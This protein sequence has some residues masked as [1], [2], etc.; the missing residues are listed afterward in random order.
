MTASNQPTTRRRLLNIAAAGSLALCEAMVAASFQGIG[1]LP[2]G[3]FFSIATGVSSNGQ[4]VVGYSSSALSGTGYEAFRWAATNGMTALGDLPGGSFSSFANAVSEDGLVIVGNSS[5][6]NNNEAFRWT[7]ATGMI[8][9]GDLPGGSVF[10]FA[11]AVSADG[12]VVIGVSSS[13]LSGTVRGEAFRW[14][15]TNGMFGLGDLPGGNFDSDS[16]G[17]SA[18][19]SVIVGYSSSSNGTEAF[20]WTSASGMAPLGDLA[21]GAFNSIAYGV[22][23]DGS[24][25]VGYGYTATTSHEAFRWTT[26]SGLAALG[27]IPCDTQSIARAVSGDGSIVVGDPQLT[28]GDCIFIWDARHG[29]RRLRDVLINDYGLNLTGWT[30]RQARAISADG[31]TIVGY[32]INPSGQTEGWIAN[33]APPLLG[34]SRQ[35]NHIVLS[36]ET[37]AIGFV[38]EQS[39]SLGSSALWN[40][41][42]APVYVTGRQFVVTNHVGGGHQFYRLTTR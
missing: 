26:G 14:T 20:R 8:G 3:S 2:G 17:I 41:N 42:P 28:Q 39:S 35:G 11:N 31:M 9:L 19:G 30:L 37:N 7:Q 27:F 36:W 34:I 21:G 12:A 6:S 22:S 24:T 29:T 25:V 18:D 16:Y 38:L 23:A 15:P 4:V 5:S 13:T 32:G 1:D 40:T 33:L 10:S